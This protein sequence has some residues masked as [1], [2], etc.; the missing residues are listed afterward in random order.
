[1]RAGVSLTPGD[2]SMTFSITDPCGQSSTGTLTLRV[3]ND[4][5]I[6]YV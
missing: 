4:V 3:E 6:I 1:M 2:H 5:S